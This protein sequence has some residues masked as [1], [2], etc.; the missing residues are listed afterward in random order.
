MS[1]KSECSNDIIGC[2]APDGRLCGLCWDDA[3]HGV[4]KDNPTPRPRQEKRH[5]DHQDKPSLEA[6]MRHAQQA[7]HDARLAIAAVI[8]RRDPVTDCTAIMDEAHRIGRLSAYIANYEEELGGAE[9]FRPAA[10]S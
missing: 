5:M 10:G 7:L 6:V 8:S 2:P 1:S 3:E 9:R 4:K